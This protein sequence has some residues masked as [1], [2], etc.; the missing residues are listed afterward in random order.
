MKPVTYIYDTTIDDYTKKKS[1][2]N[3]ER[4]LRHKLENKNE[5]V[6]LKNEGLNLKNEGL[7][8]KK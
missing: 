1:P 3:D 5:G 6:N 7:N 4:P 8:F 2:T